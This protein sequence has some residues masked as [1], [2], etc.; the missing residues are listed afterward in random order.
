MMLIS[1]FNQW[2]DN[3]ERDA[4]AKGLTEEEIFLAYLER[5]RSETVRRLVK[6]VSPK[7]H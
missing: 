5:V 2:L 6:K 4:E 1:E 3:C 7:G